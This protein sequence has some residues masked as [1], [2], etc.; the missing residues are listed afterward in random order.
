MIQQFINR[1]E[2]LN[3]LEERFISKKPEFIVMYGRR[4]V[5]KMDLAVHFIRNKPGIYFL[6]RRGK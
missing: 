2:E 1:E 5:G 6:E 3:I 4:R